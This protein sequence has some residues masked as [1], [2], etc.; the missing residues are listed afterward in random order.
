MG[1]LE[2]EFDAIEQLKKLEVRMI[3]VSEQNKG[4]LALVGVV[5][6]YLMGLH[7]RGEDHK[8]MVMI[9]NTTLE[10]L[11]EAESDND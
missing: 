5:L 11:S 2:D 3:K 7:A 6:G 1:D 9:I 4:L 8:D 10:K